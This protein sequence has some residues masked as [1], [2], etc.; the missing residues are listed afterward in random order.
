MTVY[1]T[2][3]HIVCASLPF[4]RLVRTREQWQSREVS[5]PRPLWTPEQAKRVQ[6]TLKGGE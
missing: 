6:D 4:I 2:E 1:D 5:L 3:V